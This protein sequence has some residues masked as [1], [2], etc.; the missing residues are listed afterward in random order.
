MFVGQK[1]KMLDNQITD[2]CNEAQD[3]VKY[4][5]SLEKFCEPLYRCD[6]TEM[7][8]HIPSLMFAIRMIYSTS[9]YYNTTERATALLV[10]VIACQCFLKFFSTT[11]YYPFRVTNQM[12]TAC[13]AFLNKDGPVWHQ[14]KSDMIDKMNVCLKLYKTYYECFQETRK[15]MKESPDEDT[16]GCS[17]MYIFG[18]FETFQERLEK[19][20]PPPVHPTEIRTSISPSSAVELQHDKRSSRIEGIELYSVKFAQMFKKILTKKYDVLNHRNRDFDSDYVD[21]K[22]TVSNIEAE[23]R[24][25]LSDCLARVPNIYEALRLLARWCHKSKYRNY[26]PTNPQ[27][28]RAYCIRR[29]AVCLLSFVTV[30][31]RRFEKLQ[32]SCLKLEKWYMNVVEMLQEEIGRLRDMYNEERHDPPLPRNMP[33]VAGRIYWIRQLYKRIEEPMNTLKTK[34]DVLLSS[35]SVKCIKMYNALAQCLVHYEIIYH[36]AWCELVSQVRIALS[37]PVLLKNPRTFRYSVNFDLY[38]VEVIRETE[39]MWKLDLKVPDVAQ[40]V[41]F[42]KKKILFAFEQI[43]KLV[44]ENDS[45][46]SD[47]ITIFVSM[48]RSQLFKM[49]KAFQPGLSV[50]T[51]TSLKIPHFCE[52]ISSILHEVGTFVKEVNDLKAARIDEVLEEMSAMLLV[53]L[54]DEDAVSPPNFLAKNI[55]LRQEIAGELESKSSTVEKAVIELIN[56]FVSTIDCPEIQDEMFNWLDPMKAN[57][58]MGS[59]TRLNFLSDEAAF[60]EVEK[61][62]QADLPLIV[63]DCMEMF[64]FFNQKNLEALVAATKNSLEALR[65]RVVQSRLGSSTNPEFVPELPIFSTYLVVKIPQIVVEPT[66]EDIQQH[67]AQGVTNIIDTHKS[68]ILWGER[69]KEKPRTLPFVG[70]DEEVHEVK[71]STKLQNYHRLV[72]EHKEVTRGMMI[73]HGTIL[74]LKP[75]VEAIRNGPSLINTFAYNPNEL[76]KKEKNMTPLT[77]H[78]GEFPEKMKLALSVECAAWKHCLG[79]LL[80][81]NYKEKLDEM[82]D[83]ISDHGNILQRKIKDLDDVRLA[84]NCLEDVRENF[85][86]IDMSLDLVEEMYAT[87]TKFDVSVPRDDIERVD[88]LRSVL[89]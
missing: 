81:T 42:S 65:K 30:L 51:W 52:N 79:R 37:R 45:I 14:A 34:G 8:S 89:S 1:W 17:E 36:N 9:R 39:Y 20:K 50:I 5:Y 74:L 60:R 72:S 6:P 87:F 56:C 67:F 2:A 48:I 66:L 26:V 59:Q 55:A 47:I 80:K 13:K 27:S 10:K 44:A 54:P 40:I 28:S 7:G 4:L 24:S 82:V 21:F 64:S 78:V 25:F 85:I 18:K 15:L 70:S 53:W 63:Q 11:S 88:S 69:A 75:D 22:R 46:R 58:I 86:H 41:A 73:L 31:F 57:R 68:I 12:V 62:N 19:E 84:M 77:Y 35:K 23:L 43:K 3:N 16:F 61:I 33:P 49:E 38:I 29:Q 83:F 71:D 32:L 76:K